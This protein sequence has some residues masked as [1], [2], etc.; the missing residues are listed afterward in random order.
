M[1]GDD[2]AGKAWQT[3]RHRGDAAGDGLLRCLGQGRV[4]A[5]GAQSG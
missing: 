2:R 5:R 1:A 3:C 4:A